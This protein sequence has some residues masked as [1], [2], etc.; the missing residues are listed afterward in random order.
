MILGNCVYSSDEA[1]ENNGVGRYS[2]ADGDVDACIR[3]QRANDRLFAVIWQ[4]KCYG[5]STCNSPYSLSGTVNYKVQ[6]CTGTLI[7]IILS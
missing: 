6:F 4:G 3:H 7:I 1:C 2:A 5:S